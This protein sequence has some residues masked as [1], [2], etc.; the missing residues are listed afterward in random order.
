MDVFL[1]GAV[2]GGIAGVAGGLA[3][4]A[5]AMLQKPRACPECGTPAPKF[6]KPANRR[7][8]LWGG[9]TCPECGCEVD[10][11]GRKVEE[12]DDGD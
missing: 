12:P 2:I 11:R 1:A 3:V 7:Q 9:W 8:A 6:R 4:L 10:R 5:V